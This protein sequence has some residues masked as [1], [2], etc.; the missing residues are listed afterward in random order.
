MSHIGKTL[1]AGKRK[2][3]GS[4][5]GRLEK[6]L[7]AGIKEKGRGGRKPKEDMGAGKRERRRKGK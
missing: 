4:V 2:K 6:T 1:E 5:A 7:V 3:R